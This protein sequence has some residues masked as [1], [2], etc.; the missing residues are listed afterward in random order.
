MGILEGLGIIL[1]PIFVGYYFGTLF[2]RIGKYLSRLLT[3]ILY[4]LLFIMGFKLA[5]IDDLL[6]KIPQVGINT[7]VFVT[8]ISAA[9]ILVLMVYDHVKGKNAH[10]HHVKASLGHL[11][12]DI[13][14]LVSSVIIGIVIGGFCKYYNYE[15]DH[16]KLDLYSNIALLALIFIVGLQLGSAKYRLRDVFLNREALVISLL[17]TLSCLLGGVIVS[18][19][20]DMNL[21][22]TLALSSGMGWYS[23]TSV[24]I[25]KTYGALD[26]SL[27]FFVDMARELLALI[28]VPILMK[29]YRCTAITFPGATSLDCSLPII[30]KA[31]GTGVVGLAI[32][33]GFLANLYVPV[34]LILFTS[35]S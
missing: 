19:I 31:G 25:T 18:F 10:Y 13:T 8:V 11:I 20:I 9:N 33:F 24:V 12:W 14:K 35:L 4:I 6:T 7:F 16:D 17:F 34:L 29:K 28:L 26:G 5:Q 22:K 23:L 30:Q 32:S 2:P 15:V 3:L 1:I 27:V 21:W